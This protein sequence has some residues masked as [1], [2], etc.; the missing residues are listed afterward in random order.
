MEESI[1]IVEKFERIKRIAPN[2]KV[3]LVARDPVSLVKSFHDFYLR[4]G[5]I[6]ENIND[7]TQRQLKDFDSSVVLKTAQIKSLVTSLHELFG[8]ENVLILNFQNLQSDKVSF[9]GQ[10]YEFLGLPPKLPPDVKRNSALPS[11]AAQLAMSFPALWR[12]RAFVPQRVRRVIK[13]AMTKV[14]AKPNDFD[15]ETRDQL[16][17]FYK[18]DFDYAEKELGFS[19]LR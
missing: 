12:T 7:W 1:S 2:S 18:D 11:S 3:I 19:W 14:S 15:D 8:S 4:G 9:V 16:L 5:Q 17:E 6:N 13:W 10:L